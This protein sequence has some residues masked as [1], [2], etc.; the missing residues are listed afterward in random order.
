MITKSIIKS[1]D[2]RYFVITSYDLFSVTLKS[3]NSGD[4]WMIMECERNHKIGF[5]VFHAHDYLTPRHL[6]GFSNSFDSAIR[7]IQMHDAYQ[8]NGRVRLTSEEK[9]KYREKYSIK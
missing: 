8:V 3:N 1:I 5:V 6:H 9:K 7:N 2:R 4:C